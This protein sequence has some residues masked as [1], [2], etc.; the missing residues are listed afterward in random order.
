[1]REPP[2][3]D[4]VTHRY[5]TARGLRFHYAE[6]GPPDGDPVLLLHGWPQHF[7]EWRHLMPALATDHRVIALDLRGFGWSD[8]PRFGYDKE[9]LA[10]DVLAVLDALGLDR[11]KLVGHDWGG[12]IGF[13]L[14]IREPARVDRFLALG[15]TH[16][17][18]TLSS[19]RRHTHRF[20]YQLPILTPGLGYALHR[21]HVF[22]RLALRAGCADR[23]TFTDTELDAF[24]DN[25]A[26]PARSRACVAVYRTF[27][28][29]EAQPMIRGRYAA[30]RMT[31]RTHLMLGDSDPVIK[32]SLIAGY[33]DHA[34]AMTTE[35]VPDC[36]HFIADEHPELV[37]ARAR[38]LFS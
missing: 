5:V 35:I 23:S 34:D 13:L 29:R 2:Q 26:E 19:G 33:E 30:T 22:I 16:P 17:W 10:T 24:A 6:A 36:G 1:V 21:S 20:L 28:L 12:W 14:C 32:P 18:Q 27:V 9:N 31:T 8:A 7:Y 37:A 3:L 4:G 15:V 11:V 25:L 38:E